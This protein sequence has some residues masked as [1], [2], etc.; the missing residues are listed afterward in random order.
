MNQEAVHL[1]TS[2]VHFYVAQ[3]DSNSGWCL[4]AGFDVVKRKH[5][6]VGRRNSNQSV[7]VVV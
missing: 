7:M 6:A 1:S 5:R 3:E 4:L 2:Q